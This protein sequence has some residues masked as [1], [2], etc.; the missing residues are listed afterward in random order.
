MKKSITAITFLD[1]VFLLLLSVSGVIGGTAGSVLYYFAFALPVLLGAVYSRRNKDEEAG[2]VLLKILP[3]RKSVGYALPIIVPFICT[4]FLISFLTSLILTKLGFSETTDVSGNLL[5][6]IVK[7][8]V[9]P[10]FFEEALFRFIPL[11]L[12]IPYSKKNALAVSSVM[13]AAV[14]CSL[15]QIPYAL[16]ASFIL[17]LTALA[18]GSVFPCILIHFLNNVASIFFMRYSGVGYFNL[19]FFLSLGVVCAI[20]IAVIIVK[21]N[22]YK[23]IFQELKEDK[24]NVEFTL[25]TFMFVAMTLVIGALNLWTS[26]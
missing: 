1:V 2:R 10:A 23:K 24:C 22:S 20:S 3:D 26:L 12:L 8:A 13:F 6:V 18:T 15:F 17:S 16:I 4:V 9:L 7:H 21:R 11:V 19:I 5:G 25:S 14:H